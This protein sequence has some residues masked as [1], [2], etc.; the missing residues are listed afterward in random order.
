MNI[1]KLVVGQTGIIPSGELDILLSTVGKMLSKKYEPLNHREINA[2]AALVLSKLGHKTIKL[3]TGTV[4]K[5]N[6]DPVGHTWILYSGMVLD[7]AHKRFWETKKKTYTFG[8]IQEYIPLK[9]IPFRNKSVNRE[10][11]QDIYKEIKS[12]IFWRTLR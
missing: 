8:M 4:S 9:S 6:E 3:V 11:A 12:N 7:F 1:K 2:T 10:L 5:N